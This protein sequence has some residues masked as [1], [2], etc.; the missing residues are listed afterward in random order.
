MTS[1]AAQSTDAVVAGRLALGMVSG[2]L[3]HEIC[4]AFTV[5]RKEADEALRLPGIAP[6]AANALRTASQAADRVLLIANA[7]LDTAR[8]PSAASKQC[9]VR[10]VVEHSVVNMDS[11]CQINVLASGKLSVAMPAVVLEHV[12]LNV[13]SNAIAAVP[14]AAGTIEIDWHRSTGNTLDITVTD[15]GR[16]YQQSQSSTRRFGISA[17]QRLLQAYGGR[18]AILPHVPR[19]TRVVISVLIS[20]NASAAA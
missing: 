19:G 18:M 11:Q 7:L 1:Q 15:N 8:G 4:N 6:G 10:Q 20:R 13:L 2:E 16:G 9:E 12:L 3:L 14:A 17:C 5:V